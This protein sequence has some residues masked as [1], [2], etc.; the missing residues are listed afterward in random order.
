MK[1]GDIMLEKI[2]NIEMLDFLQ[3]L[4]IE[5]IDNCLVKK[6]SGKQFYPTKGEMTQYGV[7]YYACDDTIVQFTVTSGRASHCIVSCK[8]LEY[9]YWR[10]DKGAM[11]I[12]VNKTRARVK[13][14]ITITPKY[15]EEFLETN[16]SYEKDAFQDLVGQSYIYGSFDSLKVGK[17]RIDAG[18]LSVDNYKKILK[19]K[20]ETLFTDHLIR[21]E[22]MKFVDFLCK[23]F[24]DLLEFP[25]KEKENFY[26]TFEHQRNFVN[27]IMANMVTDACDENEYETREKRETLGESALVYVEEAIDFQSKIRASVNE[28]KKVIDE[29]N[30]KRIALDDYIKYYKKSKGHT[31]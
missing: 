16:I 30:R 3:V 21:E 5:L 25:L 19:W 29:I 12:D 24:S 1:T 10:N 17:E 14:Q 13:S 26:N 6:D 18:E 23:G 9:H 8:G 2:T 28:R 11:C 15:D 20:I 22:Y 31:K 7:Y 4:E 27:E